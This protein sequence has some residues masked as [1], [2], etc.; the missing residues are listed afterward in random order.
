MSLH[1]M[2][3]SVDGGPEKSWFEKAWAKTGQE[4]GHGQGL[5]AFQEAR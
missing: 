4:L 2:C 1:L 3:L 5:P